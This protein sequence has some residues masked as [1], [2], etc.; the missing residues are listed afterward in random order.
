VRRLRVTLLDLT[1]LAL[2][3]LLVPGDPA[4]AHSAPTAGVPIDFRDADD[5]PV[6]LGRVSMDTVDAPWDDV[7]PAAAQVLVD[8]QW[9]IQS[10]DQR[11][12]R[13]VT[14]WK[15][16][17]KLLV[18]CLMGRVRARCVV[19][20]TALADGR[21]VVHFQG[22]IATEQGRKAEPY[23]PR[24]DRAYEQGAR[25]WHVKVLRVMERRR[26]A[27]VEWEASRALAAQPR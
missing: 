24:V 14:G 27:R 3:A 26:L 6:H 23:L 25:D 15:P 19:G 1:L 21:S 17:Q 12:R 5:W 9:V 22:G 4:P 18:R 7:L 16:I 11:T 2:G 20:V 13:I 10:T 8:D